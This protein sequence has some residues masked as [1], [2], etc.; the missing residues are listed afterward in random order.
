M[1]G[2]HAHGEEARI[3]NQVASANLRIITRAVT[4]VGEGTET[5]KKVVLA[6]VVGLILSVFGAF[7][8]DYVRRARAGR[9]MDAPA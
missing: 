5:Q 1:A 9:A 6:G 4:P 3:A 7:L 2:A 8:L